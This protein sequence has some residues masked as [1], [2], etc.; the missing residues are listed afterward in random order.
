MGVAIPLAKLE[1]IEKAMNAARLLAHAPQSAI[2]DQAFRELAWQ[3]GILV[4]YIKAARPAVRL[5]IDIGARA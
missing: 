2:R 3:S 1:D 5:D 4:H